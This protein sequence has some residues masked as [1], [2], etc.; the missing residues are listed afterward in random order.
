MTIQERILQ[1]IENKTITPY[2][3]CKNLGLS[4]GYLDKRGAIRTDKYLKIIEY[5][6]DINPEWLLTGKGEMFKKED[7]KININNSKT[8]DINSNNINIKDSRVAD[9]ENIEYLKMQLSQ[10]KT[11]NEHLQKQ[12]KLLEKTIALQDK[13][14]YSFE[15]NK[16]Q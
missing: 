5:L 6:N 3:F 9:N 2:R 14:I 10:C 8:G 15:D 16:N 12:I 1:V 4:M 13:L 7:L 11:N